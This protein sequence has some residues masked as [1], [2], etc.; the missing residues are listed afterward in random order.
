MFSAANKGE[1]RNLRGSARLSSKMS[2]RL[3][4][5]RPRLQQQRMRTAVIADATR[6]LEA[7]LKEMTTS[8]EEK[9]KDTTA[10]KCDVIR[11]EKGTAADIM[12]TVSEMDNNDDDDE[13][14]VITA[15]EDEEVVRNDD[16]A[17]NSQ[18]TTN[19]KTSQQNSYQCKSCKPL[20]TLSNMT[21]YLEHLQKEHK[22]SAVRSFL[23][24]FSP[25]GLPSSLLCS[26]L[27]SGGR[28]SLIIYY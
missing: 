10:K 1:R 12:S 5:L 18:E 16:I 11:T 15:E 19:F 2:G 28:V 27:R 14:T 26:V 24:L 6:K 23:F 9:E 21:A 25:S 7:N 22:V 20:K 17:I 3:S 4:R 13:L 8:H